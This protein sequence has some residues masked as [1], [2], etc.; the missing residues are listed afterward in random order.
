MR[1][2]VQMKCLNLN[3]LRYP[4]WTGCIGLEEER[5]LSPRGEVYLRL[6]SEGKD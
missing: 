1:C 3:N 6:D 4:L 5:C 2:F